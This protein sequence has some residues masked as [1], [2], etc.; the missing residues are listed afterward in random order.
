MSHFA[1]IR[2]EPDPE[3]RVDSRSALRTEPSV[4]VELGISP[5]HL[6]L[7]LRV[8][9]LSAID[10]QFFHALGIH[11]RG[12]LPPELQESFSGFEEMLGEYIRSRGVVPDGPT[13]ETSASY[14]SSSKIEELTGPSMMARALGGQSPLMLVEDLEN[15]NTQPERVSDTRALLHADQPGGTPREVSGL[16]RLAVPCEGEESWIVHW[17]GA[18]EE[19][20]LPKWIRP[21]RFE[22]ISH[23]PEAKFHARQGHNE[24]SGALSDR[25]VY[26]EELSRADAVGW[27]LPRVVIGE[28]IA[29]L[30]ERL[31]ESHSNGIV[32]GD[33]KPQN[34]LVLSEGTLAFDSLEVRAGDLSPAATPGWAAPEQV[35]GREIS[36][37][38]DVF[39]LGLMTSAL[40]GAA[41]HGEER[42]FIIPTGGAN[43]HRL[44]ILVSSDVFLDPVGMDVFADGSIPS[45][46]E[47]LKKSVCFDPGKRFQSGAEFASGLRR[48]LADHPPRGGVFLGGGPGVIHRNVILDGDARPAWVMTDHR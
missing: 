42:T 18:G 46:R 34:T 31:E 20:A 11:S 8:D 38:T 1:E 3:L 17:E 29:E 44:R 12:E 16:R 13:S 15:P 24:V 19:E 40:V 36:P 22:S 41:I 26:I 7:L 27:S 10:S 45:W 14:V 47:F 9:C 4:T 39:A 33:L 23:F 6:P 25:D 32:H 5:D 28:A 48:R 30:A 2:K 43:R 35:L 37:A 21:C